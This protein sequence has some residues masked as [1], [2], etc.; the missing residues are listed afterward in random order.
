MRRTR[1]G[2]LSGV[3]GR[4]TVVLLWQ[5]ANVRR[6]G[7]QSFAITGL[8][9]GLAGS[10]EILGPSGRLVAGF[11]AEIGN[12]G[13]IVAF[14]GGLT[15]V[16]ALFASVFFACLTAASFSL[17]VYVGIPA[18]TLVVLNGLIA[19]L[20]SARFY[21]WRWRPPGR[22]RPTSSDSVKPQ[23]QVVVR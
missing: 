12:T 19:V 7:L 6:I 22:R 11:S 3:A 17:P 18:A 14:V 2:I 21:G 13:M 4:N 15:V 9:A 5:G 20:V 10:L 1:F 23:E 8:L 16:G